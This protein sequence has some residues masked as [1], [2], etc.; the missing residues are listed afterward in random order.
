MNWFYQLPDIET[1]ASTESFF[2]YFRLAYD[3]Q[4][5]QGRSVL[6]M[7]EFR[8]RLDIAIPLRNGLESRSDADWQLARRLLAESY[9]AVCGQSNLPQQ[10]PAV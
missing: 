2:H 9:L 1:L 8:A 10:E 4:A 7:R 6:L 3:A 5:L